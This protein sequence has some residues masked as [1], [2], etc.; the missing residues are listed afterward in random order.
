MTGLRK[1]VTTSLRWG[2]LLVIS[3][4]GA[5]GERPPLDP[6]ALAVTLADNRPTPIRST[7]TTVHPPPATAA[8]IEAHTATP[9]P[10]PRPSSEHL[11]QDSAP[12]RVI[13]PS[14]EV[15][16]AIISIPI[17]NGAWDLS[18]LTTQVG[19][20]TT[21]G[22]RPG[23]GLAMVLIG[24]VTIRTGQ[25]GPFGYLWKLHSGDEVVYRAGG[26]DYTYSIRDKREVLPEE[27]SRL[28]VADGQRLLLITCADWDYLTRTYPKRLIVQAELVRQA[29]AQ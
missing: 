28:Y 15:D 13:I 5:R 8:A 26:T 10:F 18:Q 25:S 29:S 6:F 11:A 17:V 12:A 9:A 1:L 4:I 24:H 22:E 7:A 3:I 20:L 21:T 14:L 23:D 27:V 2:V 19:W 16:E